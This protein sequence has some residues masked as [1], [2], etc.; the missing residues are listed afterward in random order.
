MTTSTNTAR[1]I[2]PAPP[3]VATAAA[4]PSSA[5]SLVLQNQKRTS[6]PNSPTHPAEAGRWRR[7]ERSERFRPS[8]L[9]HDERAALLDPAAAPAD[10][11]NWWLEY[12]ALWEMEGRCEQ[13]RRVLASL[14]SDFVVPLPCRSWL[15]RG[16]QKDKWNA[17]RM[18]FALGISEA[19]ARGEEVRFFTLTDGSKNGSMTIPELSRSWDALVK[20]LKSGGPAPAKP[21]AGSDKA[22]WDEWRRRCRSRRSYLTEY[23]MVL[24]VGSSGERRL[25]A[26]VLATGRYVHQ[27]KLARFAREAGFG[28]IVDIRRVSKGDD[29]QLATYAAK[30]AG[31]TSK[32]GQMS[33]A[34]ATQLLA[35]RAAKRLRP[36]RTSRGWSEGGLRMAEQLTGFRH[37]PGQ[38]NGNWVI[39]EHDRGHPYLDGRKW[40]RFRLISEKSAKW[41]KRG[42][43]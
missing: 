15:C 24:E 25:H 5:P 12:A 29:A 41:R 42:E 4:Q 32:L 20:V 1:G 11:P 28:S 9:T 33:E 2:A 13:S 21:P 6:R 19:W 16:C 23:A 27:S 34:E 39:I 36:V 35:A 18:L 7:Q 43:G 37:P 3:Q 26:H 31:Y 17:A 10:L 40:S 38:L 22:A 14:E 30:M 8:P